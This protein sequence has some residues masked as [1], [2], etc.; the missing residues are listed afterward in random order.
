MAVVLTGNSNP[1]LYDH[2]MD[3]LQSRLMLVNGFDAGRAVVSK[4]SDGETRVELE[5]NVRGKEV[6]IVQSTCSPINDSLMELML[7]ADAARRSPASKIVAVIPYYGYSRQDRRPGYSRVPISAKV[8]AGMLESVGVNHVITVDLHAT[9]AQGFFNIPVDN[10]AASQLFV[11]DIYRNWSHAHPIIVSPDVGGVARARAIAKTSGDLDLAIVDKRRPEANVSEVMHIIGDVV[12]KTCILVDDMVDT[13][14]TLCKA[15]DALLQQGAHR[16][17]AYC[18][19]PVLSGKAA[20]NLANSS[21]SQLIVTDT[22]P[23]RPELADN[24]RIRQLSM[25]KLLAETM[26]CVLDNRSI[27]ELLE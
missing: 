15:A 13:A 22:I 11:A 10:I 19:H 21:L 12:D 24:P 23:L 25:S 3:N 5:T 2:I 26:R 17:V 8:I 16:V 20:E 6:F 1:H 18:T 14:G 4:F 27:S 7:L 9:Q